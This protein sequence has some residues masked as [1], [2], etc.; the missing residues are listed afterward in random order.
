[1]S[2]VAVLTSIV[3]TFVPLEYMLWEEIGLFVAIG[4]LLSVGGQPHVE[5]A[6][7]V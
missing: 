5:G 7:P 4:F 3:M 6:P 1:M 2:V